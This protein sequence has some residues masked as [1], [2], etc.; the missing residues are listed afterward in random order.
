MAKGSVTPQEFD[1][2]SAKYRIASAELERAENNLRVQKARKKQAEA[3]VSYAQTRLSFTK[4][5]APFDGI[6]TAKTAEVGGLASPGS[7]LVTLEQRGFYRL[8]VQVGESRLGGVKAGTAVPV[9]IDAIDKELTGQIGEIVPAADP[10]SRSF[11]VKIDIPAVPGLHSG[12][13][14][15]A[16]F[17]AGKKELL[18]VPT[19]A[20]VEK[21]QLVGLYV[22][23]DRGVARLRLVS[24]GKQ[25]GRKTEILSGLSAG[26]RMVVGGLDKISDGSRVALPVERSEERP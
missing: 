14:G 22:V 2:V 25:Y 24:T 17:R 12:L 5:S 19:A 1:E 16:R 26:E 15:K 8:E 18:A 7:P 21:G 11:T 13:Y 10:Q 20:L 9:E 4:I 3:K 6:V 23:D